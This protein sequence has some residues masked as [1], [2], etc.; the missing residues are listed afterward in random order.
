VPRVYA[1][2]DVRSRSVKRVGGAIGEA[3]AAVALVYPHLF[4]LP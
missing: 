1:V 4:R 2:G 3:V